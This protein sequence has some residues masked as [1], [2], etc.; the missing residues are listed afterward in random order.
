MTPS[1]PRG[2][3]P[4]PQWVLAVSAEAQ[5]LRKA[6]TSKGRKVLE[7]A[8]AQLRASEERQ[9]LRQRRGAAGRGHQGAGGADA[10]DDDWEEG[11]IAGGFPGGA[12]HY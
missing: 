4:P 3:R 6:V 8:A 11:G 10:D 7:G 12:G 5:S 2:L 9:L 1:S